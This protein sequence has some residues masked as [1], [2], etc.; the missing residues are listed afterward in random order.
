MS[1]LIRNTLRKNPWDKKLKK[2]SKPLLITIKIWAPRALF[3][4]YLAMGTKVILNGE[5]FGDVWRVC[6][7]K[8]GV[9][10]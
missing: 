7:L 1:C 2:N 8:C 6:G 4:D 9:V 5:N 3:E 10:R